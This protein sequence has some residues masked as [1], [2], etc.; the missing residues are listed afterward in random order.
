M[1]Y[2]RY[3]RISMSTRDRSWSSAEEEL[4]VAYVHKFG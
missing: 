3:R 4:L 1:C 2:S